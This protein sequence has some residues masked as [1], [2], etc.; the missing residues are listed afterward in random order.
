MAS[1]TTKKNVSLYGVVKSDIDATVTAFFVISVT[2]F[3]I[4]SGDVRN[5]TNNKPC[6]HQRRE[7]FVEGTSVICGGATASP[8]SLSNEA[9][10]GQLS[11]ENVD[12]HKILRKVSENKDVNLDFSA[13]REQ[14]EQ[15]KD[16]DKREKKEKREPQN[17]M[18]GCIKNKRLGIL[19]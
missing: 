16:K 6:R 17:E 18:S 12:D 15:R 9:G 4:T 19:L 11:G 1:R 13:A 3:K 5:S 10:L 14:R 2:L 7:G 8:V